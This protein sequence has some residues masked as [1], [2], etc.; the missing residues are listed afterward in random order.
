MELAD[1][2]PG[3][4]KQPDFAQMLA[5][6]ATALG[7]PSCRFVPRPYGGSTPGLQKG[8]YFFCRP[9]PCRVDDGRDQRRT[10]P[11]EIWRDLGLIQFQV[12]T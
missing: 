3:V 10:L 8:L 7:C 9:K 1:V 6:H 4:D 12:M 5:A 2:R 11:G